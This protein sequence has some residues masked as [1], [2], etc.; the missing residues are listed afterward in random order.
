MK[1]NQILTVAIA[2]SAGLTLYR[3]NHIALAV[4]IVFAVLYMFE[5]DR[6]DQ[7]QESELIKLM[8]RVYDL[9]KSS[10]SKEQIKDIS[11][12]VAGQKLSRK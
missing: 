1:F 12:W 10:V 5:R 3:G 11:Q 9:E 6:A 2:I 8:D 7:I 4:M